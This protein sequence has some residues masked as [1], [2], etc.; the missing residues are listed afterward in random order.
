MASL[1][2]ARVLLAPSHKS[3]AWKMNDIYGS[4]YVGGESRANRK[5]GGGWGG[6]TEQG[7]GLTDGG[8]RERERERERGGGRG[9]GGVQAPLASLIDTSDRDFVIG[10]EVFCDSPI[11]CL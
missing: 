1:L 6:G 8:K 4:Q 2:T 5:A 9:E 11:G 10:G 3:P 7:R